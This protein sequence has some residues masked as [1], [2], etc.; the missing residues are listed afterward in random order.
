MTDIVDRVG[1]GLESAGSGV[2]EWLFEP[3]LRLGVTGMSRAGK[4]VFITALVANLLERSRMPQLRAAADGTIQSAWLRPQ[5]DDTVPRF[6]FET[7]MAAL[8]GDTP[9]WPESTRQVSQLRLSLTLSRT[10]L[11]GG[12]AGLGGL[13]GP[14]RLH[15]DIVDYP[16]EWLLDLGLLAKSFDAWS[17]GVLSRARRR[18]SLAG[19]WLSALGAADPA[20]P[21]DE[22]A[23]QGLATAYTGYLSAAREA[24]LSDC[25]PGR[26]LLPG[27]LDGSPALTFAPMPAAETPRGSLRREMAR[28]F[29]A[30]KE[31]VVKPFFHKHFARIDRQVVLADV[32]DAVAAGPE[33]V[34]E[35][36]TALADTLAVFRPGPNSWL[37][38]ILGKRV[39]RIL[40]AATKADYLHHTQHPRLTAIAEALLR[41]ARD[42]A[43]Y[44]GARTA[45]LSIAGL[46][47]TVETH[48]SHDGQSLPCVRGRLAQSGRE[49]ALYAGTLPEDPGEILRPAEGGAT[50]WLDADYR[51]MDFAPPISAATPG[52]GLPHIRLDRAAEFLFGDKLA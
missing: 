12:I 4:T 6:G 39:E 19:G 46:R 36:R 48:L 30:Y 9:S 2:S 25:T 28:R 49:A 10:G 32:L 38:P 23:A 44:A 43:R 20:A 13:A 35:L 17:D 51:L 29:E 24:G 47:A 14:R 31:H 41:D 26:F 11:W 15:L 33:A 37:A 50:R 7:H 27:E 34:A 21:F 16:G 5:P 45:A 22:A 8:S 40:F 1:R 52:D 42:R 18:P 3:A